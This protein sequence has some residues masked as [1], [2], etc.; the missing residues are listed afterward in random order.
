V[1]AETKEETDLIDDQISNV[2]VELNALRKEARSLKN[3]S[4]QQQDSFL[5]QSEYIDTLQN[6]VVV[7]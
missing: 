6:K 7:K 1:V 4:L 2:K 5:T 3:K